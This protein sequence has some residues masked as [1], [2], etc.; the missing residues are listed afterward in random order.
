MVENYLSVKIPKEETRSDWLK[1]PL[2]DAQLDY[3]ALDVI[4]LLKVFKLQYALLEQNNKLSW[5]EQ[6]CNYVP[7]EIAT[8][9]EPED[10]YL[11]VKNT[12]RL[13]RRQLGY[14]R[15]LCAWRETKARELDVPRNRVV[16]EKSL[17]LIAQLLLKDKSDFQELAKL[18]P[19]QVRKYGDELLLL[20]NDAAGLQEDELPGLIVKPGTPVSS[21]SIQSLRKVV[22]KKA[23]EIGIA[24]EMLAKRRHLEQLLRSVDEHGR[25]SLPV[26]FRGWREEIIGHALLESLSG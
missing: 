5:V 11:K 6:E 10:F 15:S 21:K 17:F 7:D 23:L 1:R 13:D 2:T 26:A 24:P 20:V 4:Y 22:D 3:A 12:T 16:E 18:S 25:Y 8:R 19:R 9:V 14:L